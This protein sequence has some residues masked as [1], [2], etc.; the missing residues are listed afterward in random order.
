M[1]KIVEKRI[2]KIR[3]AVVFFVTFLLITCCSGL[4]NYSQVKEEKLKAAYTAESTVSRVESQLNKYLAESNLM[5]RIVEEG[6]DVDDEEFATLSGLMQDENYVIEAHEMAKDGIVGQV[7]PMK[8]NEE[9]LGLN[10]L[11]NPARKKEANLAKETGQYT[12]AGPYELVQGGTGALLFDP[13]YRD[14]NGQKSFWGFSILVI[15]WE[16]FIEDIE[17]DKLERA[18]YN[19]RIWKKN[20]YSEEKIIIAQN[21]SPVH[22]D[23][24]EVACD[25]PNDTWYFE[26]VPKDGWVSAAQL[27][28]GVLISLTLAL[29]ATIGYWLYETQ[30]QK[31]AIYAVKIEKVARKAQS[32]SE[33]KT[34]FLFN[35]SHDIRTP[36]N[37]IIGFSELL[38]H[39]LDDR[40][41]VRDYID[42]IRS[43]STL[44]LSIINYVLEMARIKSGKAVLFEEVGCLPELVKSL[45][46]VFEPT[47]REK[48]LNYICNLNVTHEY[49]ICDKTKVR[50]IFMNIVS[51]SIKYTKPGGNVSM[52]VNETGFDNE[53][54]VSFEFV[55]RDTGIGMSQEYLPH[56]FEEFSR[57]HT[58]TESRV[59][60]TGLG[61]PIVKS[62]VDLMGG[63]VTVESVVD[64]GTTFTLWLTFP[65][66]SKEQIAASKEQKK[67]Q[68]IRKLQGRRILLAEDNDL[69]AEIAVTILQENGLEADRVEDGIT[70]IAKL[71]NM[72]EHYYD[73][74]LMDIQMPHM[75]GYEATQMIR[76][77]PGSRAQ[78]PVITMTA[79]AFEEDRK[80]AQ[81]AGMNGHIAKPVSMEEIFLTL[82]QVLDKS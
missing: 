13:I 31:D 18:N 67:Q 74:I 12:I 81:E 41:R 69:N 29:L 44:L 62:L 77:L 70:C 51:N 49:I 56:I 72:P 43:S 40:E 26:I 32:V 53:K 34:R 68:I 17:L 42:K 1:K 9:A 48:R 46:A 35:M 33:A 10:M 11:E 8:G 60:G 2:L 20:L 82:E 38:E 54:G 28:F 47:V 3:A 6:Y 39:H 57:E 45:N 37:A 58:S 73:A 21:E 36:M 61:L 4:V 65:A 15:N 5:K 71:E 19:Y 80:K 79:N 7:Y 25:V 76:R 23:A 59:A 27:L 22:G 52:E 66:A 14:H 50:E 55:I 63:S 30:Q 75:D 24:L 78:I 64:E 16:K